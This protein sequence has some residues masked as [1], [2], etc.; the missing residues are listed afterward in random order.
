MK[1]IV[2]LVALALASSASAQTAPDYLAN[3]M[4]S[5]LAMYASANGACQMKPV[6]ERSN[7]EAQARAKYNSD[8]IECWI[9]FGPK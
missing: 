8:S 4:N 1:T 9:K 7:C 3:C 2:A 5:A 6:S